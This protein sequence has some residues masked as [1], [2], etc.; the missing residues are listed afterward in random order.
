MMEKCYTWV[1]IAAGLSVCDSETAMHEP[2]S[3]FLAE[4]LNITAIF[5]KIK[6]LSV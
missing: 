6:S 4:L 3:S 1:R 2:E 5:G